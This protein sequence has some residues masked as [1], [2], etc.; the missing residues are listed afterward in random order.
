MDTDMA[1]RIHIL[2]QRPMDRMPGTARLQLAMDRIR[3]NMAV[4]LW[5][6][7]QRDLTQ[8]MEVQSLVP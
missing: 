3:I 5:L 8:A 2:T 7:M 1:I 6:L 4:S